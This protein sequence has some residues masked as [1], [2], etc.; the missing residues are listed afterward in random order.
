E[1]RRGSDRSNLAGGRHADQQ[2][3]TGHE[4]LLSDQHREWCSDGAANDAHLTDTI[5]IEGQKFSVIAGPSFMDA[6]GTRSFEVTDNVTVRIEYADFGD[7][8]QRQ[9]SLPTRLPQ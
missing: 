3:A 9:P 2:T 1:V 5:E 7:G 8:D 4:K 6:A